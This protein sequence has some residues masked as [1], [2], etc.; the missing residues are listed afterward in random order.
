MKGWIENNHYQKVGHQN[1]SNKE[2]SFE[3]CASKETYDSASNQEQSK[4]RPFV[5]AEPFPNL[6]QL[7]IFAASWAL[8]SCHYVRII[9][10][11]EWL[12]IKKTVILITTNYDLKIVS[13]L[14]SLILNLNAIVVL[15]VLDLEIGIIRPAENVIPRKFDTACTVIHNC[16]SFH[17]LIA[18]ILSQCGFI[19]VVAE[20]YHY[21]LVVL[22]K[23]VRRLSKEIKNYQK[24]TQRVRENYRSS[25]QPCKCI[26]IRC[27]LIFLH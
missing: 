23:R 13:L 5:L 18:T 11:I 4:H 8:E 12:I 6:A 20:W 1:T 14:C 25:N 2:N 19:K 21:S 9:W 22:H 26:W 17:W 24:L 7:S 10:C 3:Q 15:C 27:P 16:H